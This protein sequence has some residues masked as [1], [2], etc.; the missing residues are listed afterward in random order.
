MYCSPTY[1]VQ[2]IHFLTRIWTSQE[3]T[4]YLINPY[5][6]QRVDCQMCLLN[7]WPAYKSKVKC[8]TCIWSPLEKLKLTLA[9]TNDNNNTACLCH[10]EHC[11]KFYCILIYLTPTATLRHKYYPHHL[12][13]W[14]NEGIKDQSYLPKVTRPFNVKYS[15]FT[16][17]F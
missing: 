9:H 16:E 2:L 12:Y 4:Q 1:I 13:F 10:A 14:G 7:E 6:W 17:K 8:L 15:E 3:K 11:S 5:T